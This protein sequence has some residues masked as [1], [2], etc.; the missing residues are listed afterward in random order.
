M[1]DHEIFVFGSNLAGR[2]GRGAAKTAACLFGAERGQGEGFQGR[3]YALPTKDEK[4]R[5][6]P[7]DE[8]AEHVR[9]FIVVADA[10]PYKTFRLTAIGC[11][12]AGYSAE[13]IKPLF[14]PFPI[15][16]IL[17]PEWMRSIALVCGGRDYQRSPDFIQGMHSAIQHFGYKAVISGSRN[18][19]GLTL[20]DIHSAFG[21]DDMAMAYARDYHLPAR[22]FPADWDRFG[23]AAGPIRNKRMLDE[24]KPDMI[25]AFP[26]GRGTRNMIEKGLAAGIPVHRWAAEHWATITRLRSEQHELFDG[27]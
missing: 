11:G 12:L 7:L 20:P 5:T 14:M 25:L 4:L 1:T 3:S 10:H 9:R 15:N 19:P 16:V 27:R 22:N 24:G 17:P 2:H 8:I 18:P 26:G 21:V 23:N 6:L 13:Q